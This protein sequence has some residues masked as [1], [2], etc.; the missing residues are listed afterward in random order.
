MLFRV[1]FDVSAAQATDLHTRLK[2]FYGK[3]STPAKA[4]RGADLTECAGHSS[5]S[6]G[7]GFSDPPMPSR[8]FIKGL[9]AASRSIFGCQG[10]SR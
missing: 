10:S 3:D 1:Y 7:G 5:P 2:M 6:S 8:G 9:N 4:V